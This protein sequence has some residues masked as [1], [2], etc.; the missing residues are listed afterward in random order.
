M[1]ALSA[2]AA[3]VVGASGQEAARAIRGVV[4]PDTPIWG[5]DPQT[6][7]PQEETTGRGAGRGTQAP[8]PRP[9][10]QVITSAAKTNEGIFKVHRVGET[11]YYEI[12]KA[13]LN[14]DYLWVTQIKKTTIGVGY[15]GQAAG[16]R[17]VRWVQK[18]DRVLLEN[19]DFSIVADPGTPI[20]E[21]VD[22]ANY[23]AIIRA[24]NVA[25]YAPS[26]DP[27]IDVT[28][29][30]MTDV[31]EFSVRQRVGGRG[32]D[33]TRSFL[34]RA[35]AFPQNIDVEVT[36][37]FTGN[38]DAAAAAAPGRAGGRATG[39]R[40][41]SGTVLTYHSMIKL[42]E[43][44]MMP[45]L[46]DERVG[47]F[48]QGTTDYGTDEHR[49]VPKRFITRYRLEKKDPNAAMSE[50]V[51]PIVYYIDPA[52]PTKWVPYLK[53]GIEDWQVA[54]EAAG[55]KNAILAKEA[56]KND[57]DWAPEDVRYSVVRW[58]PSTTENASGPNVHDPRTGE[59][60]EADIQFYHNVQNLTRDWYFLQV[61]P[62][63]PRAAKLPLPDE[64]MGR[65][66]R[67]VLAHEIGHT[68]GFQHNMKSSSTYT[69]EQIRDPKWVKENGH[70]PSIMDYSRFNYV[71]QPEDG[72]AID[73]LVPKI[74]PYDKWATHWGYAP[75]P[76][77]ATPAQEK[78]TLDKWAREQDEKPYLR[79]S[80][81]GQGG[82]DPGDETEAVG[83][84]D[85]VTATRLGIKNLSRVSEMLI[86]ATSTRTG[87]PWD[88]LEEVYGRMIGQWTTEMNH[89]VRVVGGFNSQQKHIGQDGVR[90]TTV[91][92]VKQQE[93]VQFLI[94]NAF[95]TPQF[96]IRPEILRR[97]QTTGI[98][99][100]V[101][102]SQASILGGLLQDSRLDRM[103]EQAALDGPTA[104][105]PIMFLGDLRKGIWVELDTPTQAIDVYRRNLQRSYLDIVD[106][107]LNEG[108]EPSAEVR[109]LLKGELRALDKQ[110]QTALSA[111]TD[112]VT[113]RHL[114]DSRD[115][116][117]KILDPRAMR[118]RPAA[119]AGAAGRGGGGARQ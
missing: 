30:F 69:I 88:D 16:S 83:D 95:K 63:D 70:S 80:T 116:I 34:E 86:A 48:T 97:I 85:A 50:P 100:R 54:F 103:V 98:V 2:A 44:A 49:S 55:F 9:Y 11:L 20:A 1:L 40:G 77:A 106:Q 45:R 118:T 41:S 47:Y 112:E 3:F 5:Q 91:T 29:L 82:T 73:D 84:S 25:A 102:T 46:F 38:T 18:G 108:T 4:T 67:Y 15:G 51:K 33:P 13:E 81:E 22:D 19:I 36:Q 113:R 72:I 43:K 66:M 105:P 109:S 28:P 78:A 76:G 75:I 119:G 107:R 59:I 37:T 8:A 64:L 7:P 79:F 60:L 92:R 32:F 90:F 42:P 27:V 117:T 115:E 94:A 87:D 93:A 35:I 39:M 111:E 24:F 12:P 74:G 58:L 6:P 101:R 96:M 10:A 26:G 104:Y 68:L 65:L 62:L 99:E 14:R 52:T 56:P 71:A 57:P 21:A 110:L 17:V 31:P 89:V 114:Q 23:P 61:G 53:Q